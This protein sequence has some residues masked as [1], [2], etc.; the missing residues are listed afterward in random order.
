MSKTVTRAGRVVGSDTA[1]RAGRVVGSDTA[2]RAGRVV[3]SDTA[4]GAGRVVGSDTAT[5]VGR[6]VGS[7]T[8]TG[9]G[10]VVG[11]DTATGAGRVIRTDTATGAGR[12]ATSNAAR[13]ET[14]TV[15]GKVPTIAQFTHNIYVAISDT[16]TELLNLC[17]SAICSSVHNSPRHILEYPKSVSSGLRYWCSTVPQVLPVLSSCSGRS[18]HTDGQLAKCSLVPRLFPPSAQ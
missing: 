17:I 8:A 4:T 11:S 12:V 5:G 6:V 9:A 14:A 1:T 10:R 18:S 2:T 16:V 3:G 7:D 15:A 13:Y